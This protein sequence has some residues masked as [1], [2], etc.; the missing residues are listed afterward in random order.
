[1]TDDGQGNENRRRQDEPRR[2][3]PNQRRG[4]NQQKQP[5][6]QRAQAGAPDQ[7]GQRA[8]RGNQGQPRQQGTPGRSGG[9][10]P[11][12]RGQP[13]Q[14]PG[15]GPPGAHPQQ[16]DGID[17]AGLPW[18]SGAINGVAYFITSFL[19]ASMVFVGDIF[20]SF[21]DIDLQSEFFRYGLGWKYYTSH[22]VDVPQDFSALSNQLAIPEF[23]YTVIPILF[24]FL[25]GRSIARTHAKE[26]MSNEELAAHG[27]TVV[28]GYLPLALVG[29]TMLKENGQGPDMAT[30]VLLMGLV[31]PI[32]FGG[33]GGY[34]AR[35]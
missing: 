10:T 35:R 11:T 22:F 6:Q 8:Q 28:A 26:W 12:Q 27:A 31:F 19:I 20:T 15:Q 23:G 5:N 17:F 21:D 3:H 7:Q 4:S 33:L 24:L 29:A 9:G 1:M 14:P 13:G 2:E 16:S 25:A 32:V 18:I 30:T 34:L